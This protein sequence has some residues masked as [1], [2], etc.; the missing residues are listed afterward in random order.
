MD[1]S[2]AGSDAAVRMVYR[3]LIGFLS[4]MDPHVDKKLVSG[5]EGLEVA[6]TAHPVASEILSFPLVHMY[7]LYMPHQ[8]ILL[9]IDG[10]AVQ[11]PAAVSPIVFQLSFLFL[12]HWDLW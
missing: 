7:F 4:R 11:P 9:F 10:T 6:W 5:I 1:F 12:Q 2:W 3:A 8:L